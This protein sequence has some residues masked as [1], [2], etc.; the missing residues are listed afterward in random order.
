LAGEPGNTGVVLL[1]VSV[2]ALLALLASPAFAQTPGVEV[3]PRSPTAQEYSIPLERVRRQADP[4]GESHAQPPSARVAPLFGEGI[5]GQSGGPAG[6]ESG[7]GGGSGSSDGDRRRSDG[8]R[9][10]SDRGDRSSPAE[11]D[12]GAR[13]PEAVAAAAQQPGPPS[14]GIGSTLLVGGV[15]AVVLVAGGVGGLLLRRRSSQ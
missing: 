1:A 3:D 12:G 14:G 4:S 15:A 8:D 7:D 2:L 10:R 13:V 6:A 11:R 9:R 5:E